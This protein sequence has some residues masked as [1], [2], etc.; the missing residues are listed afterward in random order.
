[1]ARVGL[2]TKSAKL[3]AARLATASFARSR[4]TAAP[5]ALVAVALGALAFRLASVLVAAFAAS[6]YPHAPRVERGSTFGLYPI[7]VRLVDRAVGQWLAA[8]VTAPVVVSWIA[9]ACAMAMLLRVA[10]LDLDGDHADGAVLL[11]AVFP[12]ASVFGSDSAEALFLV[13]ALGAFYGFRTGHW[14]VGGLCGALA[15]ATMPAGI[16]IV[17]ALASI[18]LRDSAA[19]RVS[20]L[21]GLALAVAGVAAYLSYLYYRGGPVGGWTAS[22]NDWGVRLE[23]AP[24]T[25]FV[26]LFTGHQPPLDAFNVVVTLI[27]L[28]TVP[29][30]WWRLNGG[31][32]IY[33]I[34]ILLLPLM[35]ASYD[36]LGR[37]C[38]LLFPM[39]ILAASIRWRVAVVLLAVTSAMFYVLCNFAGRPF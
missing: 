23:Q 6:L 2:P 29:L 20:M 17:P 37:A 5:T 4:S 8:P 1:M 35:S 10:R 38:A 19:R 28:A 22:M 7:L 12:F 36:A 26:A 15:T 30:V 25:P 13:F 14:L 33:M 34:A 31:Y 16:L 24:W 18:G 39:F 27:A 21:T 3:K 32:A 9:F 11:A